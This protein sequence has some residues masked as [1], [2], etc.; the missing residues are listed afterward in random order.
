MTKNVAHKL[1]GLWDP[2]TQKT[3]LLSQKGEARKTPHRASRTAFPFGATG[4]K[5]DDGRNK[6]CCCARRTFPQTSKLRFLRT[7]PS[8]R[9]CPHSHSIALFCAS[10]QNSGNSDWPVQTTGGRFSGIVLPLRAIPWQREQAVDPPSVS[11]GSACVSGA[12]RKPQT[13]A[14]QAVVAGLSRQ[15][16]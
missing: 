13:P 10:L 1:T 11:L 9:A 8:K 3:Y 2:R 7:Q 4:G 6:G 16:G 15:G 5:E 14:G 12:S